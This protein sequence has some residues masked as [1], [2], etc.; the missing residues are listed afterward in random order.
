M[1]KPTGSLFYNHI[2][3]LSQHQTIHPKYIYD[4]PL[5]QII[6]WNRKKYTKT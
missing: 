3:I 1:L 2:D 6:I 4:F 5:K